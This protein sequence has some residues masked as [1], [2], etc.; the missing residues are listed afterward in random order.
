MWRNILAVC[1]SNELLIG[2]FRYA[3]GS[4]GDGYAR[5]SRLQ[6][7]QGIECPRTVYDCNFIVL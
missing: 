5:Q 1:D 6:S 2:V 4:A 7:S 3:Y